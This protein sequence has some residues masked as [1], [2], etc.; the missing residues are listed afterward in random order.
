MRM[1]FARAA[2]MGC[3]R[4]CDL[5]LYMKALAW[6]SVALLPRAAGRA[7]RRDANGRCLKGTLDCLDAY[8]SALP[9][10]WQVATPPAIGAAPDSPNASFALLDTLLETVSY[11]V[12]EIHGHRPA[13]ILGDRTWWGMGTIGN[14][15][16][17]AHSY[18][19]LVR[20]EAE[21]KAPAGLTICEV[22]LNAG[23]SAV[24]FLQAAGRAA[25]LQMFDTGQLPYTSTALGLVRRLYPGQLQ[26]IEGDSRQTTPRFAAERGRVCDVM[27]IDGAHGADTVCMPPDCKQCVWGID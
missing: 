11:A 16:E 19:G 3:M 20:A 27:S 5:A 2:F 8:E 14:K 15:F 18:F 9:R 26:Y 6:L 7:P 25:R 4:H 23:H 21:R 1:L 13:V 24:V 22:G 12:E 10:A 17:Q